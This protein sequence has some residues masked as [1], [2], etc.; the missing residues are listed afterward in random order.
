[1]NSLAKALTTTW[2]K[3]VAKALDFIVSIWL[4]CDNPR[5]HLVFPR[6]SEDEAQEKIP[7]SPLEE[8]QI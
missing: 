8:E 4:L 5:V 2:G 3:H 6:S 7:E 1:M